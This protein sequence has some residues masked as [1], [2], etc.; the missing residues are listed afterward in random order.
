MNILAW[1]DQAANWGF[2]T[3][4]QAQI[5]KMNFF[6]LAIVLKKEKKKQTIFKC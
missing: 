6:N 4:I 5:T 2:I 1:F 3:Y